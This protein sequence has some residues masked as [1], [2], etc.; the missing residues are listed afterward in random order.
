MFNDSIT[1][2]NKYT[3][4]GIEKWKRTVISGVFFDK[5]QGRNFNKT[6]SDKANKALIVIPKVNMRMAGYLSPKEFALTENKTDKWTLQ[7]DDTIVK[8]SIL[9]EI[10]KS[11]KELY[12]QY[13]DVF[14]ITSV[15]FKDFGDNMANWEVNAK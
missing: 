6:G 10:T 14:V 12:Q 15:D 9:H 7:D 8:G 3:L 2:Y 5:S 13:D 11:T 1:L 4:N